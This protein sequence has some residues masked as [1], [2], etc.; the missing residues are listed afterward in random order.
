MEPSLICLL[1]AGKTSDGA[2][3]FRTGGGTEDY[4][5]FETRQSAIKGRERR[6]D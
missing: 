5:K 1:F 6:P 3:D 2:E 4:R